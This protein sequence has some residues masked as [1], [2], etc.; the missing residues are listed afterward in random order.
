MSLVLKLTK[1]KKIK[2]EHLYFKE[3]SNTCL[4]SRRPMSILVMIHPVTT[5]YRY[6]IETSRINCLRPTP[7]ILHR[8]TGYLVQIGQFLNT[9]KTDKSHF[10]SQ[11]DKMVKFKKIISPVSQKPTG[12]FHYQT[13]FHNLNRASNN[14]LCRDHSHLAVP[15]KIC[16]IL[17]LHQDKQKSKCQCRKFF[18]LQP[19]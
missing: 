4:R 17:I 11:C 2:F 3:K 1:I 10:L 19:K 8:E 9:C 15:K 16:L 7:P 13:F 5:L 12:S 14:F 18:D 6:C